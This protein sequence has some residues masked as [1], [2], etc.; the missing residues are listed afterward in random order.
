MKYACLGYIQETN[1]DALTPAARDAMKQECAAYCDT[2]RQNGHV[3]GGQALQATRNAATLRW[4]GG[5]AAVT[6]GP[7]AETKEQLGG[8]LLLDATDLNHA[9]QLMANHPA[10]RRGFVTMEIRPVEEVS[11]L[12]SLC[13]TEAQWVK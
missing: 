7:F 9:I 10:L 11:H 5:R 1:L 2:L 8:I 6:D 12:D 13:E 3:L 4:S